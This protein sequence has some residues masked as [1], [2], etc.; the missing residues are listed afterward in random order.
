V[1]LTKE[2]EMM[3]ISLYSRA[4]DN[5]AENPVLYDTWAEDAVKQIDYDFASMKL[6]NA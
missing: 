4:L 3:L 1:H 6:R 2:K 5:H